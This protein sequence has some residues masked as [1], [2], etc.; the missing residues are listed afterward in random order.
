MTLQLIPPQLRKFKCHWI[1]VAE[2]KQLRNRPLGCTVLGL[3][4]VL[5][6]HADGITAMLDRCPHRNVPLSAGTVNNDL[7]RCAYHG[8]EFDQTG[9]CVNIPGLAN[10]SSSVQ[11]S[12]KLSTPVFSVIEKDG[13][14]FV[15]LENSEDVRNETAS[16]LPDDALSPF[17]PKFDSFMWSNQ[18]ECNFINSLENLLD[19]M[20]PAFIH[21]LLVR[22][23][24]K[25]RGTNVK[26]KR[27]QEMLEVAYE[28]NNV[29]SGLIPKLF[30]GL[31]TQSIGRY[32]PPFTAQLEYRGENGTRFLLTTIFSPTDQNQTQTY[33]WLS[34][35]CGLIPPF[36]KESVLRLIFAQILKQDQQILSLQT[37]NIDR[38]NEEKFVS[39]S[40]DIVRPHIL[41]FL[42]APQFH[43]NDHKTVAKVS[44]F[45]RSLRIEI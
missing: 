42:N 3:P 15:R 37:A 22:T 12:E 17:N 43:T 36:L 2:T 24:S 19:P 5:F 41:H 39:T 18:L 27:T 34:T 11:C 35:P 26:V 32:F 14:I 20:H 28:E 8:W 44:N 21:A 10:C 4:V 13:L 9:K 33:S 6:R 38:F 30:E 23:S 25:R 45:E 7:L 40:L 16:F 1:A 29:A 31:R